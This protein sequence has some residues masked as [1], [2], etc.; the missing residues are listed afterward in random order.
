[1]TVLSVCVFSQNSMSARLEITVVILTQ[2][3]A[4]LSGHTIVSAMPV[5][6]ELGMPV[7]VR[8]RQMETGH[9]CK[10]QLYRARVYY[11]HL[12]YLYVYTDK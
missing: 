6:Q 5:T 3:V 10:D 4:M 11:S 12:I 9:I 8:V 1:M 2:S 7:K